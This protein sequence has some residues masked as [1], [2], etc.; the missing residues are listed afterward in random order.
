MKKILIIDDEKDIRFLLSNILVDENYTTI[1]AGNIQEAEKT[2]D[3]ENFDLALVDISLGDKKKDGISLLKKIKKINSDIPVIMISGHATIQIAVDSIKEGAFEFLEKPFNTSRLLNFVKRALENSDLKKENKK[4]NNLF[5]DTYE[6]IGNS[7]VIKEIKNTINKISQSDCR[8]LISGP[9]GSGKE[10]VARTIHK[11]SKRRDNPFI[12]CNGALLDPQHF[13][14]ELFGIENKD[15]SVIQGYFEKTDKGTLLIDNV[16]EIPLDTQVK[17]LRVLT[18]QK[19]RRVNGSKNILTNVRV[20]TTTSKD[21]RNETINGNF[22]EDLFQRIS[23][24]QINLP[25]LRDRIDDLPE[26]FD[27]FNK[28]ISQNLGKKAIPFKFNLTKMFSHDW[29]GNIRELRNLVER[30]I[31]LSDGK[32][33]NIEKIINESIQIKKNNEISNIVNFDSPL[34]NA[35]E[36]FEREY[37]LH[38]LKK[39][40]S[41]VSKTAENIGMERSAL[42]R[43]LTSLGI[44]IK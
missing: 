2:I 11:N 1:E 21:L 27:Y 17:I 42:H 22:R 19:F 33:K 10:L 35:R 16:S 4:L 29:D 5:F 31:I 37:L 12:V 30:L 40:G 34:K 3:N 23:V 32:Q 25:R 14:I 18:D 41:N 38:Q 43:K 39:N 8:V 44:A 13:D 26:L 20:F 9:Y 7:N 15:G 24:M 6:L 28:K 36:Q